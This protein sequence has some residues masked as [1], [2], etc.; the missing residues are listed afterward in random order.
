[1]AKIARYSDFW[2]FYLSQHSHPRTRY[3]H[4]FGTSVFFGLLIVAIYTANYWLVIPALLSFYGPAWV[5]HF[6]IE[7]NRP[8][9][10]TH[11]TW[12]FFSDVRMLVYWLTGSLS[13]EY[14]RLG[15][16]PNPIQTS[17]AG[18]NPGETRPAPTP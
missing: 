18:S 13:R 14:R 12:S 2:T 4:F 5:A 3:W 1:M 7:G 11:P 9:S 10:W 16:D 17:P 15:L 8:A 6:V